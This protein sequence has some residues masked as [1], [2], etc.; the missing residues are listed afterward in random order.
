MS[1]LHHVKTNCV[2][3]NIQKKMIKNRASAIC[4]K[5]LIV[6]KKA[7]KIRKI[8]KNSNEIC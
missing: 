6:G 3:K 7:I 2:C 4:I 5:M 8:I 1:D